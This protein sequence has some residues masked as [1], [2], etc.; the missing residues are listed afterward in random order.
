MPHASTPLRLF[1]ALC[2]DPATRT[3]L[4]ALQA[5]ISG[6]TVPAQNLHMTLAFIGNQPPSLLPVL[7][8]I[9]ENCRRPVLQMEID[10]WGYFPKQRIAWVGPS[11]PPAALFTLQQQLWQALI[12]AEILRKQTNAFRPHI[13]LTRDSQKPVSR[14]LQPVHWQSRSL[15]LI[16]SV[17]T[18]VGPVYR[19]LAEV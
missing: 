3:A 17:S 6:R 1:Y 10:S 11:A 4:I 9:L 7:I 5:Q 18:D 16:E 13:S 14:F 2:P 19:S 15:C 12:D 8:S